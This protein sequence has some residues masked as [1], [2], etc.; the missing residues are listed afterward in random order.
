MKI[1]LAPFIAALL[2]FGAACTK[3]LKYSKEQLYKKAVAAEPSVTFV[4]PSGMTTGP[5]CADYAEGCV[6]AHIVRVRGLDL[7]GIEF[8]TEAQAIYAAKKIRGYYVLNWVLDDV[9]GEPVLE[10]FVTEKLEAKKP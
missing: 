2:I 3:E 6:G 1:I 8:Q 9:A 4:L 5:S 10:K 7:I